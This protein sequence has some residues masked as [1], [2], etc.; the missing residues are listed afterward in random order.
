MDVLIGAR[1]RRFMAAGAVLIVL[2]AAAVRLG[3][4]GG[5]SLSHPEMYVPGLP[6]PQGLSDPPPRLELWRAVTDAIALDTHPPGY[7]ALMWFV[8][9]IF[10]ASAWT[11]RLPSVVF[12]VA[13]VAALLWLGFLLRQRAAGFLAAALLALNGY[14]AFWSQVARMYT[15]V[16]LLQLL[17]TALLIR[18]LGEDGPARRWLHAAYAA[19][20]WF[21]L[22]THVLFWPMLAAHMMWVSLN[23][24]LQKLPLPRILGVQTLVAIAATPLLAIAA[25]QS[26]NPVAEMSDRAV[27][28]AGNLVQF[29]F[30]LPRMNGPLD[31]FSPDW[32]EAMANA[33]PYNFLWF[34]FLLL[35]VWLLMGAVRAA[36]RQAGTLPIASGWP[37]R[38]TLLAAAAFG[39]AVNL[40]LLEAILRITPKSPAVM[41]AT[42]LMSLTPL[43]AVLVAV[44]L[45][46][47]WRRLDRIRRPALSAVL[48]KGGAGLIFM[49]AF[50]PALLVAGFSVLVRPLLTDRGLAVA[51]PFVL[52]ALATGILEVT[53]Q[54]RWVALPL[55]VA[56]VSLHAW[57]VIEYA[58][59]NV[60]P[61]DE[62]GFAARI[63][64][65]IA[66]TDL[67]FY[68]IGWSTT[69]ILWY[70][71]PERFHIVAS[72]YGRASRENP[73]SRVWVLRLE[74]MPLAPGIAESLAGYRKQRTVAIEHAWAD[75]Y[76]RPPE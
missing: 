56:L 64:P 49:A 39:M 53:R 69:P 26:G 71:P 74:G 28:F 37:S 13:T 57:S 33:S 23:A 15:L 42:K 12:G 48:G 76:D 40:G 25:Y 63:V 38:R 61:I 55:L 75:L 46:G 62:R 43:A 22:W 7:Y 52:Y 9:R 16:C 36:G 72:D 27:L 17:A 5:R 11:I 41:R 66:S 60:D 3:Q 50:L 58:R 14:H 6:L 47:I 68:Q 54:R 70:L 4:V 10:G 31:A 73:A 51:A 30:L 44:L 20:V 35:S 8:T 59:R 29:A 32:T 21:G 67:I 19:L 65:Q 24:W 45:P 2:V 1:N 34:G 18:A